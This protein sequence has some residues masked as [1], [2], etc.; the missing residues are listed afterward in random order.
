MQWLQKKTVYNQVVSLLNFQRGHFL[1]FTRSSITSFRMNN[2]FVNPEFDCKF[3]PA[4]LQMPTKCSIDPH[5][6]PKTP[7]AGPGA[8]VKMQQK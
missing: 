6:H 4:K 8:V 2:N 3:G 5:T 1:H 7:F